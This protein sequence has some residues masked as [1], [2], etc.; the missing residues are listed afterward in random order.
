MESELKPSRRFRRWNLALI[1][2]AAVVGT[3]T[4][5]VGETLPVPGW[6]GGAGV[7]AVFLICALIRLALALHEVFRKDTKL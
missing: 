3:A 1:I 6:V 5:V 7:A 2:V 4:F